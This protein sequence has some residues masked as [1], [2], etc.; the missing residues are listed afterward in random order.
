MYNASMK[1][2]ILGLLALSALA[3]ASIGGIDM[4]MRSFSA[5]YIRDHVRDIP[6]VRTIL[7]LGTSRY[8]S[9][10]RKNW[11]YI[12]RIRA[13]AELYRHKKAAEILVSGDGRSRFYN[14]VKSMRKDLIR[15]GVSPKAIRID[16]KGLSTFDSIRRAKALFGLKNYIIVTQRFQLVRAVFLARAMGHDAIGY[17]AGELHGTPAARRMRLREYAARVKAL[18]DITLLKVGLASGWSG[19]K[20]KDGKTER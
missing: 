18:W 11:Y 2:A 20:Q 1:K 16:P 15:L 13:A 3:V 12:Y 6:Q 19:S 8:T 10:G 7:L 9:S 4:Y 17:A 14:E 5:L